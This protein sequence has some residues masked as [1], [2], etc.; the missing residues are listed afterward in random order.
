V[1]A[2]SQYVNTS[3][4]GTSDVIRELGVFGLRDFFS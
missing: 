1:L 4:A 2:Y 3:P